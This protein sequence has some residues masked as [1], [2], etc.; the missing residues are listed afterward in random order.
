MV[1]R[2]GR[3]PG[4]PRNPALELRFKPTLEQREIVK[5][6]AGYA[7]P[8]ERIV[9]AIRN[10]HTRLPISV[11]TLVDRFGPELEAGR[12]EVDMMLAKGLSKRLRQANMTALIWCSKNLWNWSD[13]LESSRTGTTDLN[14]NVRI[15]Q[16]E[17]AAKLKERGLPAE[18]F[19]IDRPLDLEPCLIGNGRDHDVDTTPV[20]ATP[21]D[22]GDGSG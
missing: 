11:R 20:D 6:L 3:K 13:K 12:A 15:E 19:G 5:V 16:H 14:M 7:I 4:R 18:I 8:H 9:K 17:L 22:D 2:L 21:S 1:R 10:P